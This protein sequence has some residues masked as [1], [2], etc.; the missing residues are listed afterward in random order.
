MK[1]PRHFYDSLGMTLQN[2]PLGLA[3]EREVHRLNQLEVREIAEFSELQ[4]MLP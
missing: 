1:N 2:Q 4:H 3:P